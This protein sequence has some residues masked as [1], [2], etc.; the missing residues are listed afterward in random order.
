M[1]KDNAME[2]R[3]L[4]TPLQSAAQRVPTAGV[5]AGVEHAAGIDYVFVER[6]ASVQTDFVVPPHVRLRFLAISALDGVRVDAALAQPDSAVP[7]SA[8]VL[9]SVHGS[10]ERY[11]AG[12]NGFLARALAARGY[13]VLAINTRQSGA[14][15]NTDNFLDRAPG[16]R[17]GRL[18]GSY[19]GLSQHRPAQP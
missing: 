6:P 7:A 10:G 16:P 11:D 18:H 9:V 13:A 5:S 14:Q 4:P 19:A 12:V 17:S 1:R 15:I 2:S 3:P 8:T